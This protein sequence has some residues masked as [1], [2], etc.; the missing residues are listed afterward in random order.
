MFPILKRS[1]GTLQYIQ[2][3]RLQKI[4]YIPLHAKGIFTLTK[5]VAP[6]EYLKSIGRGCDQLADKFESM[7]QLLS[8]SSEELETM[9]VKT[10]MRKYLLE[11]LEWF[12]RGKEPVHVQVPK[13][14][15]KYIKDKERV[16]LER[17]KKL[18]L[19]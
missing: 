16:K 17:M 18:G 19:A 1:I 15:N 8:K 12:R 13:R 10:R 5:D 2:L 4:K 9:G 6:A 3:P 7:E 11:S 14:R